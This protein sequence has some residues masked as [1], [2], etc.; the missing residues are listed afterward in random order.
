MNWGA[1]QVAI[2]TD[3]PVYLAT[4]DVTSPLLGKAPA[5]SAEWR[6]IALSCRYDARR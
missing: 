6:T 3:V 1:G 5:E 2:M 4:P